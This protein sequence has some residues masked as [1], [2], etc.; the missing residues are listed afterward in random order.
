MPVA[1]ADPIADKLR[2]NDLLLRFAHALDTKDFDGYADCYTRDGILQHTWGRHTGRD[3]LADAVRKNLSAFH[4]TQHFVTNHLID[5]EGDVATSR[6]N[7]YAVHLR[8]EDDPAPWEVGGTYRCRAHRT[9]DGWKFA[10]VTIDAVWQRGGK[11][12]LGAL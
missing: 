2:I 5:V 9:A 3:G 8:T 7:L 4:R 11:A 1:H 6:A 12:E 10:E